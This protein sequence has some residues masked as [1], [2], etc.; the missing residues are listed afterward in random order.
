M[1]NIRDN[2]YLG[3]KEQYDA[4]FKDFSAKCTA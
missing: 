3:K 4:K 2:V 1:G